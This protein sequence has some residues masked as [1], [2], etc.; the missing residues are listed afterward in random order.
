MAVVADDR[1]IHSLIEAMIT[2][3]GLSQSEVARRLGIKIQSLAQYKRVRKPSLI[4]LVRLAEVTGCKV[5]V[6]LPK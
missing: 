1:A 4:W 3:S 2:K 5:Y 6:E